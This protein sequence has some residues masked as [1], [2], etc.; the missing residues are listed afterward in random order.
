MCFEEYT[1]LGR[2]GIDAI[3][4]GLWDYLVLGD[5][6]GGLCGCRLHA[7]RSSVEAWETGCQCFIVLIASTLAAIIQAFISS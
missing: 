4:V 2:T 3:G 1:A 5:D 7:L 6:P